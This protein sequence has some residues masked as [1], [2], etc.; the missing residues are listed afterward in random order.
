MAPILSL[1]QWRK[2]HTS[3]VLR[4]PGTQFGI[5]AGLLIAC[6]LCLFF[7]KTLIALIFLVCTQLFPR[8]KR[9]SVALPDGKLKPR[10]QN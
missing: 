4:R 1:R 3:M 10:S 8:Y 2:H 5:W 6:I 9:K 7:G